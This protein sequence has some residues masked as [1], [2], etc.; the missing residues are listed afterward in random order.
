VRSDSPKRP[1]QGIAKNKW[2]VNSNAK[3]KLCNSNHYS[4]ILRPKTHH[5]IVLLLL[6]KIGALAD[7]LPFFNPLAELLVSAN[8]ALDSITSESKRL[9]NFPPPCASRAGED[10]K[11]DLSTPLG[12]SILFSVT[13]GEECLCLLVDLS[14]GFDF[15]FWKLK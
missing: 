15:G 5:L 13:L 12:V 1:L 6:W 4:Q 11:D 7:G 2:N 10:I 9:R 14:V 8:N 3:G